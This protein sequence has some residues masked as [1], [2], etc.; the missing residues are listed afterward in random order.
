L[1]HAGEGRQ[2][3]KK[4]NRPVPEQRK[5]TLSGWGEKKVELKGLK[6]H[7]QNTSFTG[8]DLGLCHTALQAKGWIIPIQR[9]RAR[10]SVLYGQKEKKRIVFHDCLLWY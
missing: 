1:A 2:K 10:L 4:E 6:T 3:R 8:S 9:K 5:H 7:D